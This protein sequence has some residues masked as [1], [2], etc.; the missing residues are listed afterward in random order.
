MAWFGFTRN[1]GGWTWINTLISPSSIIRQLRVIDY[2]RKRDLYGKPERN[3]LGNATPTHRASSVLR[4]NETSGLINT[5]LSCF[6]NGSTRSSSPWPSAGRIQEIG[7]VLWLCS[8]L[9]SCMEVE[10]F[11]SATAAYVSRRRVAVTLMLNRKKK[12]CRQPDGLWLFIFRW[13]TEIYKYVVA[14][15]NLAVPIYVVWQAF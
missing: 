11:L 4:M 5:W 8:C 13:T 2:G 3:M 7:F 10:R 12:M 1:P 9:S 15:R 14:A 6:M